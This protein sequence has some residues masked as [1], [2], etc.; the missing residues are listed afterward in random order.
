MI[1]TFPNMKPIEISDRREVESF[2]AHFPPYSDF[3]FVSMWSWDTK[4]EMALSQLNGNLVVQFTDYVSHAPFLSFLG[5]RD[6]EKTALDI[7]EQ[8][9]KEGLPEALRLVPEA[10]VR[11]ISTL[12]VSEDID[13]FD[14]IYSIERHTSLQGGDFKRARNFVSKFEREHPEAEFSVEELSPEKEPAVL[15]IS[16]AWEKNKIA[17][18]KE[19]EIEHERSAIKRLFKTTE[20]HP[21]LLS[22]VRS[23]GIVI[24]FSI[25]ELLPERYSISHFWKADIIH[26]GIYDYLLHQKAKNF[27]ERDV[28]YMNYEQDLGIEGLRKSKMSFRPVSFLNKFKVAFR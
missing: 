13:N 22:T 9:K 4:G 20:T 3:N 11:G 10:S 25:D 27:R 26:A 1:P 2:T 19:Y 28:A 21:L 5:D 16:E 14:Y 23:G 18:Q 12:A 15:E 8:C 7:L 6:T 17:A 24:A